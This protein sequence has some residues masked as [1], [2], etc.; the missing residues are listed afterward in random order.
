[1]TISKKKCLA[2]Y[3][4][5]SGAVQNNDT[6][7]PQKITMCGRTSSGSSAASL[8]IEARARR[9]H[10]VER[11][12]PSHNIAVSLRL[13]AAACAFAEL[14]CNLRFVA[15]TRAQPF[16]RST[17]PA[18][19]TR[20]AQGER[21]LSAMRWGVLPPE[22]TAAGGSSGP[23][24]QAPPQQL[25]T[26]NAR[27]ETLLSSPLWRRLIHT[28]RCVVPLDGFFEWTSRRGG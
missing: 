19:L 5:D 15:Q 25:A 2:P 3:R 20:N 13:S 7:T 14:A 11:Y 23:Q 17:Q 16:S 22:Y 10:N 28:R 4:T 8:L 1:M 12:R 9:F 21:E 6:I 18:V 27:I 24:Q 26:F